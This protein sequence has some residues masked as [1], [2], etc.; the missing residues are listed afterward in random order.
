MARLVLVVPGYRSPHS[1]IIV[2][3]QGNA[4]LRQRKKRI[5]VLMMMT[6]LS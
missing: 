2:N 5:G 4:V 3:Q 6:M 1:A